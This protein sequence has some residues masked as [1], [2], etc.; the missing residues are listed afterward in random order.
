MFD[1][2]RV[3]CMRLSELCIKIVLIAVPVANT[4]TN[5]DAFD[6][7]LDSSGSSVVVLARSETD[8][9]S[10]NSTLFSWCSCDSVRCISWI[11]YA[12]VGLHVAL[13]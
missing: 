4:K 11:N 3:G 12:H 13:M 10:G 2:I 1:F 5:R 9:L 8:T 7:T 6:S